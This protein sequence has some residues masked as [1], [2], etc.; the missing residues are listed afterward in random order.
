[1]AARDAYDQERVVRHSEIHD[2]PTEAIP[3]ADIV[4]EWPVERAY[5]D[6]GHDRVVREDVV[7]ERP[8]PYDYA[9]SAFS[10]DVTFDRML[11]RRAMLDRTLSVI[12][13]AVGLL[14]VAL[15]L[16]IVFQLL[17]ANTTSGFV[18]F[19][20]GLTDPFVRP[21]EGMFTNP[22]SDGAVLDSAALVAMIIYLLAAW[23]LV[24]LLWLLFDRPE[25][26]MR[27]S[28]REVHSDRV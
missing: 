7:V 11:A 21:F 8:A 9:T 10:E 23:A 27:R 17:E 18:R 20:N 25:T 26:G 12:W 13:F 6:E 19:I 24:R 3:R 2:Q 16:R 28:V 1:M 14:E 22:A 5:V 15:G 4:R